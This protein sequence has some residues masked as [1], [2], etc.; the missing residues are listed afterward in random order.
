MSDALKQFFAALMV[1]GVV[2][3]IAKNGDK[4]SQVVKEAGGAL[5]A[6]F[7]AVEGN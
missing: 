1:V 3:M 5:S 4:F 6:T 7:K 2:A